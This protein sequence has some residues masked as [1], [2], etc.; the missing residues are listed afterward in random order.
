MRALTL[1]PLA[2]AATA[3]VIPDEQTMNSL[4][5]NYQETPA[6]SLF[7]K[8]PSAEEAWQELDEVVS[9]A[10][11]CAKHV[12][13][14]AVDHTFTAAVKFGEKFEDALAGEAWL[15]SANYD[16]DLFTTQGENEDHPPHHGPPF[17]PGPP[18]HGP[19]RHRKPHPPPHH[20]KP[21]MTLYELISKSKYTTK[22]AELIDEFPEIVEALN[23]TAHNYTVFAP[24]D[25]AFK[26][27]PKHAPKP[28]KKMLKTF[29]EYHA[30]KEFFP[31][32]R[33]LAS[34]TIPTALK[35]EAIGG[36]P[37]RLST[38]FGFRGLT[39]NFYSR[40]IAVDIF[41]TNGV[42]HGVDSILLPPPKIV[43]IL[44]ILPGEFSTLEL[45]LVKTGLYAA[46]NDT[47]SHVGGT[48]FAP[49]N[50][51]FQRL[52]P[53]INAFLFS[54][55]GQKYLKALI[56]YHAAANATLYSDA[57]YP[58]E[59]QTSIPRSRFHV[60]LETGLKGKFLSVDVARFGRLVDIRVN[61]FN[62]VSIKDGIAKD[63]VI[64]VVPSVLIPPRTPGMF[65]ES[66][67][68]LTVEELKERLEPHLEEDY[69]M[70]L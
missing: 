12:F 42:I 13:D 38:Q 1:L 19:P 31:A 35:G 15:Q 33:V 51:A 32:G 65:E 29:L 3:F 61:G 69:N 67:D 23:G 44:S 24:I 47:S 62:H 7:D 50:S 20:H 39:I 58:P 45:A 52:G 9:K 5:L 49:S 6:R 16:L 41:G 40:V 18:H 60:D 21:N 34:T 64:Q 14:E 27:I 22:V 11:G 10:A 37:Q 68:E 56:L 28:S 2:V 66:S 63:G 25:R 8:I 55:Y 54:K 53:K 26:K 30:S 36:F 46:F 59:G 4:S 70:E 48:L 17:H 43:D 57:Y